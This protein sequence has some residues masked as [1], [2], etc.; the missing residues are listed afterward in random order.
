MH[1]RKEICST[2][3]CKTSLPAVPFWN[4]KHLIPTRSWRSLRATVRS[5]TSALW[6]HHSHPCVASAEK[7]PVS[8]R[9]AK[10]LITEL[11]SPRFVTPPWLCSQ[12]CSET[13]ANQRTLV[14]TGAASLSAADVR[15]MWRTAERRFARHVCVRHP[16]AVPFWNSKYLLPT[17]SWRSLRRTVRSTNSAL[18][19]HHTH[20]FVAASEKTSLMQRSKGFGHG[21]VV[22]KICYIQSLCSWLCYETAAN[23]WTVVEIELA[24]GGWKWGCQPFSCRC[25]QNVTHCRKEI[26]STCLRKTSSGRSVLEF[27]AFSNSGL[28]VRLPAFQLPMF[29]KCDALPKGDLLD[30]FVSGVH[31]CHS[32]GKCQPCTPYHQKLKVAESGSTLHQLWIMLVLCLQKIPSLCRRFRICLSRREA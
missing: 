27:W 1:C 15:K 3:F 19:L 24:T 14:E 13:A 17:R 20:P 30:M 29:S 11:W 18:R 25:S 9:E 4:S 32:F 28:E 31:S 23:Q 12:L 21:V 2:C 5:T 22:S 26:R 8:C 7:R 6:L 10:R 16:P